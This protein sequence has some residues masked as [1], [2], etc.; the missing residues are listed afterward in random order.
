[1]EFAIVQD[2]RPELHAHCIE[3][4]TGLLLMVNG[5]KDMSLLQAL[6]GCLQ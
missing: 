3:K 6:Q 4:L 1:M 2:T 5:A